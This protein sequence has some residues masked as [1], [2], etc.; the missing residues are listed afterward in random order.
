MKCQWSG[1]DCLLRRKSLHKT[2]SSLLLDFI[3]FPIHST[4]MSHKLP[5]CSPDQAKEL[6]SV[7]ICVTDNSAPQWSVPTSG[8]E[9][10]RDWCSAFSPSK[11]CTALFY[12]ENGKR[13]TGG[14][15]WTVCSSS[16]KPARE[17]LENPEEGKAQSNT[18]PF[19]G[20]I[21]GDPQSPRACPES[22]FSLQCASRRIQNNDK[23]NHNNFAK[24]L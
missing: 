5:N 9:Q 2:P 12:P 15:C 6:L 4:E 17:L 24:D 14:L 19:L 3:A 23:F 18:S 10:P 22:P 20:G 7:P 1:R 16:P 21:C 11:T 13:G 8:R